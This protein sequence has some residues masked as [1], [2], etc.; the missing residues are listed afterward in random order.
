MK[1]TIRTHVIEYNQNGGEY[2]GILEIECESFSI[3]GTR[4]IFANGAMITLDEDI[5]KVR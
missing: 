2:T 3:E 5:T 1:L 4:I